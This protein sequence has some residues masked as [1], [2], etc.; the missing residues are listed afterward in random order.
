M[1][2]DS[3]LTI[4]IFSSQTFTV[5]LIC[6]L[7]CTLVSSTHSIHTEDEDELE[8]DQLRKDIESSG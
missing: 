8:Y 7:I 2:T 1:K 5:P 4:I 3:S 6:L